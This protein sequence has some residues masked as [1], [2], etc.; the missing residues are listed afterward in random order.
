MRNLEA[1]DSTGV[2]NRRESSKTHQHHVSSCAQRARRVPACFDSLQVFREWW[3]T[4]KQRNNRPTGFC[5]SLGDDEL[6][7]INLVLEKVRDH[8]LRVL[9]GALDVP[10]DEHLAEAGVDDGDHKTAVVSTDSLRRDSRSVFKRVRRRKQRTHLDSLRVHL[11]V[12]VG[13]GPVESRVPLLADEEV[14]EVDLLKLE[15]DRLDELGRYELRRLGA[16][17]KGSESVAVKSPLKRGRTKLH[18][19]LEIRTA[20]ANHDGIG[21]SVD[22][23]RVVLVAVRRVVLVLHL[24]RSVPNSSVSNVSPIPK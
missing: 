21:V 12:L 19:R 7:E 4:T 3:H 10:V 22:D 16:W 1:G 24:L 18:G 15:L 13:L 2:T 14:R 17:C 20:K 5:E 9:L 6:R 11:V 8:L 23:S